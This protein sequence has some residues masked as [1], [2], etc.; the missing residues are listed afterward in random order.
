MSEVID[1]TNCARCGSDHTNL[2]FFKF[3]HP[4]KDEAG[5]WTHWAICP[6]LNEPVLMRYEIKV[7][8]LT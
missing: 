4:V 3:N 8:A 6:N 7:V 2:K 1:V 5:S